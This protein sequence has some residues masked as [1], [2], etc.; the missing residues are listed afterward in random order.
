MDE[1]GGGDV[2]SPGHSKLQ[3]GPERTSSVVLPAQ[4]ACGA[5]GTTPARQLAAKAELILVTQLLFLS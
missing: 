3:P 2:G 4:P 5:P 1:V